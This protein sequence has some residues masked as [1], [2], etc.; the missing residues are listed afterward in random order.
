[1]VTPEIH[2]EVN[3]P[4]VAEGALQLLFWH[5]TPWETTVGRSIEH[6]AQ[7][8]VP[9]EPYRARILNYLEPALQSVEGFVS[10]LRHNMWHSPGPQNVKA[11]LARD[12][13]TDLTPAQILAVI[14]RN[15]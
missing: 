10:L 2:M 8:G 1:M 7:Y 5:G 3:A 6:A 15:M 11:Y 12:W 13:E 4:T 14:R 9:R